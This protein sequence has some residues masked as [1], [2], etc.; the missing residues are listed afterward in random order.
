MQA[1]QL[2]GRITA[3]KVQAQSFCFLSYCSMNFQHSGE[4]ISLDSTVSL[5]K[6]W[7]LEVELGSW[8]A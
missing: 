6:D 2:S 8:R 7:D 1:C 5:W 3:S 4:L